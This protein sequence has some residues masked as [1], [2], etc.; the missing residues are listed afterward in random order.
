MPSG[1]EYFTNH[2]PFLS[3][4]PHDLNSDEVQQCTKR[5]LENNTTISLCRIRS[6]QLR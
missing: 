2:T 1:A 3:A 5:Q 4:K 6:G